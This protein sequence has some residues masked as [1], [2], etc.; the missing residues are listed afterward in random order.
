MSSLEHSA[1]TDVFKGE[2]LETKRRTC[3]DLIGERQ[4]LNKEEPRSI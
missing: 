1:Q 4:I 2:L 3:L